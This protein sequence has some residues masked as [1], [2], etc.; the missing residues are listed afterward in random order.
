[1]SGPIA[2]RVD[3]SAASRSQGSQDSFTNQKSQTS[4]SAYP[5]DRPFFLQART[6]A[7]AVLVLVATVA[8]VAGAVGWPFPPQTS[9]SVELVGMG[10][11]LTIGAHIVQVVHH[12]R[13]AR[14][15]RLSTKDG[16]RHL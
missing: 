15:F 13:A 9:E 1:M 12:H 7:A 11:L 16:I 3:N 10:C 2:A 4:P 8:S 14:R 6:L 5:P